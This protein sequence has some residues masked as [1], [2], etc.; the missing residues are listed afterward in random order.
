MMCLK[1]SFHKSLDIALHFVN[2]LYT[3]FNEVKIK[4]HNYSVSPGKE[5]VVS[6]HLPVLCIKIRTRSFQNSNKM[7]GTIELFSNML[8]AKLN[9]LI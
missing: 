6:V 8:S 1:E 5:G 7:P 3:N 4:L 2:E 9:S